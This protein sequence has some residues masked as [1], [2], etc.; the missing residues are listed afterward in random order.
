MFFLKSMI[1]DSQTVRSKGGYDHCVMGYIH[2]C[3]CFSFMGLLSNSLCMR[4][5]FQDSGEIYDNSVGRF[6]VLTRGRL[7]A[8]L[9]NK[10][11]NLDLL[12][13]GNL[14]LMRPF[15]MF[16]ETRLYPIS[17]LDCFLMKIVTKIL[18][19]R[20]MILM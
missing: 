16:R 12:F 3:D 13:V 17:I 10:W 4:P 5:Y 11:T 18:I 20:V 1:L 6:Q 7:N 15:W 14:Y 2:L 8:R 9:Q 19:R